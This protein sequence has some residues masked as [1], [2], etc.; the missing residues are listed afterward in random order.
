MFWS[1]QQLHFLALGNWSPF[2][3]LLIFFAVL[4]LVKIKDHFILN[5]NDRGIRKCMTQGMVQDYQQLCTKILNILHFTE[6]QLLIALLFLDAQFVTI[7]G[8]TCLPTI[9]ICIQ[10]ILKVT[11]FLAEEALRLHGWVSF[12]AVLV[13]WRRLEGWH[14]SLNLIL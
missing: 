6:P 8:S 10:I 5:S 3:C 9:S 7:L 12:V 4:H 2:W 14:L 11:T 1:E 13:A